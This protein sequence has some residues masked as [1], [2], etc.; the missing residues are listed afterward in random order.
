MY[1][2]FQKH[3]SDEL[4]SIKEAGL[5]KSERLICSPQSAEITVAG[6]T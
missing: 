1:N 5:Y 6:K 4:A 3:R 2:N